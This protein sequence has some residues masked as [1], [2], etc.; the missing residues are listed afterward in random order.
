[1]SFSS[2]ILLYDNDSCGLVAKQRH[3]LWLYFLFA[4]R[5]SVDCVKLLLVAPPD[6]SSSPHTQLHLIGGLLKVLTEHRKVNVCPSS[7]SK[8]LAAVRIGPVEGAS[9]C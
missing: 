4:E 9:V 1:M 8:E 6:K 7:T 5:V 3:V 2:D